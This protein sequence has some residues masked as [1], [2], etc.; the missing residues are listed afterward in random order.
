M[1]FMYLVPVSYEEHGG[2][3]SGWP[4]VFDADRLCKEVQQE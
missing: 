4:S 1:F 3:P 2:W